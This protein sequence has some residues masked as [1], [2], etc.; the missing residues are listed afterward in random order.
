MFSTSR[1]RRY[2]THGYS[3]KATDSAWQLAS[4]RANGITPRGIFIL[5]TPPHLVAIVVLFVGVTGYGYHRLTQTQM[6]K[7]R[8]KG[9]SKYEDPI[10]R[11][12]PTSFTS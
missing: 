9:Q 11:P 12:P 1:T 2:N 10:P 8:R 4:D 5:G 3:K 7:M 6:P